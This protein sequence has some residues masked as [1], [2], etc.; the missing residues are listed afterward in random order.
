[1]NVNDTEIL[2]C[3]CGKTMPL[4]PKKIA[5]GCELNEEVKIYNSLCTDQIDIV[6]SVLKESSDRQKPLA[7]A[8]TQQEKL[9]TEIAEETNHEIPYYFNIRETAGWSKNAKKSSAKISSLILDA[10]KVVSSNQTSRSLS[11]KSEGRCLIYGQSDA[12]LHV[13]EYLSDF[14]GVSAML[15]DIDDVSPPKTNSFNILSSIFT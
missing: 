5:T 8:C 13:S 1:M 7:I 15:T 10:S 4:D 12:V 3:N 2:I 11:F 6:E 14:L 9:F